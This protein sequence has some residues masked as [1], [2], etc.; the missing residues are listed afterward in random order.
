MLY[1][2]KLVTDHL[3]ANILPYKA[4]NYETVGVLF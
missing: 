2:V 1:F 3:V 4:V